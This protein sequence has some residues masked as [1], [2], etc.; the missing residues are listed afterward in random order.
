VGLDLAW[1]AR[2]QVLCFDA[3]VL[4]RAPVLMAIEPN[5]M[6]W[7]AGQRGPDRRGESG[8]AVITTWPG[9]EHG[10][11][12]GARGVSAGCSGRMPPDARRARRPRPSPSRP[13]RGALPCG[14]P[15]V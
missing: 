14:T 2:V 9:L 5:S 4:H 12:D 15:H 3:I 7:R 11:A 6:A 1:L 8:R 10:I 13:E